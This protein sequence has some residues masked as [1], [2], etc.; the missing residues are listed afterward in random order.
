MN[1]NHEGLALLLL[2]DFTEFERGKKAYKKRW[3][4]EERRIY[5]L[6]DTAR[7]DRRRPSVARIWG[8]EIDLLRQHCIYYCSQKQSKRSP[9]SF[10]HE[11]KTFSL[12][13]HD[14]SSRLQE[15][16]I[17]ERKII[18]RKLRGGRYYWTRK[19]QQQSRCSKS[20]GYHHRHELFEAQ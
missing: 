14:P 19:R 15:N 9:I 8:G 6:M 20:F 7:A 1:H 11:T 10:E 2:Q 18:F 12:N 16:K 4:C 5:E 3:T 17:R 13:L